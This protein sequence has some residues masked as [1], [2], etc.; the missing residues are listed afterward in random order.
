MIA[1]IVFHHGGMPASFLVLPLLF[2]MLLLVTLGLVM[3]IATLGAYYNDVQH[4]LPLVLLLLFYIS[5]VF[6]PPRMVP[7]KLLPLYHLNPIAGLLQLFQT[8]LYEGA[9]PV[10]INL[11]VF[12][13][14]SVIVFLGGWMLFTRY[15]RLFPEIL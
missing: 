6:C 4:T 3:P 5:P 9:M 14:I 1:L 15:R 12:G 7:E 8:V 13:S 10:P 11:A 2:G